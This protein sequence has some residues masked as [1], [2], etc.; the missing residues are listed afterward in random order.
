MPFELK[1]DVRCR[2]GCSLEVKTSLGSFWN[3]L[4]L[5]WVQHVSEKHVGLGSGNK[6]SCQSDRL[7][8]PAS[9]AS[10][11]TIS[12]HS[13]ATEP[14]SPALMSWSA[15][16]DS[17]P[18]IHKGTFTTTF[19][20]RQYCGYGIVVADSLLMPAHVSVDQFAASAPSRCCHLTLWP[21]FEL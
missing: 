3:W 20:L 1:P 4:V 10:S 18:N 15:S 17:V 9:R 12:H 6:G 2:P 5:S 7:R 19:F 11:P 13:S 16:S 8:P 14:K 21:P